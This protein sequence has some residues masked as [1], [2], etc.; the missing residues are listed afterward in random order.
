M[1]VSQPI[2]DQYPQWT[3]RIAKQWEELCKLW[4]IRYPDIAALLC[5]ASPVAV[6]GKDGEFVLFVQVAYAPHLEKL[7]EPTTY[8]VVEELF[9]RLYDRVTIYVRFIA[10][11]SEH[12]DHETPIMPSTRQ[13]GSTAP[14]ATPP[15]QEVLTQWDYIKRACKLKSPKAATL[16]GEATPKV[17]TGPETRELVLEVASSDAY[18]SL[19]T[20]RYRGIVEWALQAVVSIPYRIRLSEPG[21][22][23]P[24]QAAQELPDL[25]GLVNGWNHI[26][27]ACKQKS[28]VVAALLQSTE[29][30]ALV[31]AD[32]QEVVLRVEYDFHYVKLSEPENRRIIE[33][34]LEDAIGLSYRVRLI[35]KNDPIP[36]A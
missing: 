25:R 7:S 21:D 32:A 10:K 23:L 31:G 16:L 19:S 24:A 8:R 29:P 28:A 11:D 34:T 20:S 26:L 12:G 36:T 22:L 27:K 30:V 33:Q 17:I 35:R 9:Q 14:E 1:P 2:T 13:A 4:V 15:L 18:Q 5:N 6:I 3:Q